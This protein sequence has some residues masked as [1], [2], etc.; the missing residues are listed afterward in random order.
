MENIEIFNDSDI[1][2]YETESLLSLQKLVSHPFVTMSDKAYLDTPTLALF[3]VDDKTAVGVLSFSEQG[4]ENGYVKLKASIQYDSPE[5]LEIEATG[6]A[7]ELQYKVDGHQ[8][9]GKFIIDSIVPVRATLTFSPSDYGSE[10]LVHAP[11]DN[12]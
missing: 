8:A 1:K 11:G 10:Y 4:S 12:L 9:D 2:F 6:L 7:I 3:G 5:R